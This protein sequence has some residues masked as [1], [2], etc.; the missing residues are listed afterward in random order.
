MVW[1]AWGTGPFGCEKIGGEYSVVLIGFLDRA[2]E[3]ERQTRQTTILFG[4]GFLIWRIISGH[5]TIMIS[6][7]RTRLTA[8]SCGRSDGLWEMVSPSV[9]VYM[10]SNIA[11]VSGDDLI[12]RPSSNDELD[13]QYQVVHGGRTG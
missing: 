9:I 8:G 12:P 11:I 5:S 6:P 10:L 4:R 13:S 3:T 1:P 7:G 2:S